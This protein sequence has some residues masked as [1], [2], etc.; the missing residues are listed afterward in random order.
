M[1]QHGLQPGPA[2]RP[3][4]PQVP[5]GLWGAGW[6]FVTLFGGDHA[7][8]LCRSLAT[9]FLPTFMYCMSGGDFDVVQT[10]LRNLPEYVLLCQGQGPVARC[11][12]LSRAGRD[13]PSSSSS[14]D[15]ARRHPPPQGLRRG[16]LRPDRH[17]FCDRRVYEG[18]SHGSHIR[19]VTLGFPSNLL[20]PASLVWPHRYHAC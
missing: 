1:S 7:G 20:T 11:A 2:L 5:G 8:L 6:R 18:P 13:T 4:Q 14:S 3:E 17:Q 16:N 19:T 12:T 15:R 10:A 9:D